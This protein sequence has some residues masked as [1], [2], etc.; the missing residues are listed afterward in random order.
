MAITVGIYDD[1][2]LPAIVQSVDLL[3]PWPRA[4][5]LSDFIGEVKPIRALPVLSWVIEFREAT[6]R[7]LLIAQLKTVYPDISVETITAKINALPDAMIT[8]SMANLGYGVTEL[9]KYALQPRIDNVLCPSQY[10]LAQLWLFYHLTD[11]LAAEYKG[12]TGVD[13]EYRYKQLLD[14]KEMVGYTIRYI[15]TAINNTVARGNLVIVSAKNTV[16][17]RPVIYTDN[18]NLN[19]YLNAGGTLN[20]LTSGWVTSKTNPSV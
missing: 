20:K 4:L 19:T 8:N 7:P 2:T 17:D 3:A 1:S 11:V 18:T 5:A 6:I 13:A 12:V 14:L 9:Y 10:G 15:L 16:E